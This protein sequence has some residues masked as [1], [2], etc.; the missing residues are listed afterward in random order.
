MDVI[1]TYMFLGI[2]TPSSYR[3]AR[4]D[5]ASHLIITILM[6]LATGLIKFV[7]LS[8]SFL[9]IATPLRKTNTYYVVA[10]MRV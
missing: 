5:V 4:P 10:S 2:V 6:S 1:Y 3:S 8:V 9:M 7:L